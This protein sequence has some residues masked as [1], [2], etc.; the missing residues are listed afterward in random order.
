LAA[1]F[2]SDWVPAKTCMYACIYKQV[3]KFAIFMH[4]FVSLPAKT[5]CVNKQA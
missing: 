2:I 4:V 5:R 3:L 1:V